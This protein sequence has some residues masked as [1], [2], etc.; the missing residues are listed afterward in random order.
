MTRDKL[1]LLDEC[2]VFQTSGRFDLLV[3]EHD[4]YAQLGAADVDGALRRAIERAEGVIAVVGRVGSGK[5]SLIAA[6]GDGLDEGFVPLRVSVIG[7]EAEDPVAFIR[8][9]ITEI[10]DLPEVH[11]PQHEQ[12]I[13]DRAAAER[14][15]QGHAREVRAGFE[16]VQDTS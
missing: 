6:A 3:E 8:H 1:R 4:P 12:K 11:L 14:R 15:S 16:L 2:F 13:L 5:S 7:I 9:A 10:R